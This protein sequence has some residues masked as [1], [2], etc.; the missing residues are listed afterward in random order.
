[1]YLKANRRIKDGKQHIYYTLNESL[2]VN[3][4]RVIQRCVLHLG[5]LNTTQVERWQRT[6][7]T[8]QEDGQRHQLRLFTD[9]EGQAPEAE[10][11]A[12]VILSSLVLRRPRQFGAAWIGCKLWED[13][14]LRSFWNQALGED[15]GQVPWSNV[16]ELLAVNRLCAPGSELS[17]HEKWYPQTA[18]DMLLG[19]GDEV[20]ERNRLYR[21]LDRLLP[22]KE[23]LEKHLAQRWK[24]L[25]GAKFDILLYDLTSTYFEGEVAEVTKAERGYSRDSRPDCKQLVIALVVTLEGFPLSYEVFDGSRSDVTTLD[26]IVEAVER[27]H[28]QAQ[29]V[30]VFDRG[31]VSEDNL[32]KLRKRKALYLVGTRKS[33][34]K[35]HEQRLLQ[36]DWQK[37]SETVGVQIIPDGE[38]TYVLARSLTRAEKERAMR[39]RGIYG[40]MRELIR[41][42]RSIRVGKIIDSQK[43]THRLGRLHE[44]YAST[45]RYVKVE[46]LGERLCWEWDR[47]ALGKAALRDGAYLLRTNISGMDA[48]QL[49][50][51]YIQLTEVESAFR[52]LKGQLAVR[53]IWHWISSR[54]EAHVMVAF[55]GY[56]LWVT[57][58]QKLCA[59]AQSLTPWQLLDQFGRIQLIEVWFK[60]RD[61]RAICLPRITQPEPAQ[62]LLLHQLGWQLPAQPPPRVYQHQLLN[63]WET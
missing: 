35:K 57:L 59:I 40:L 58:K 30:W 37:V 17:I 52:A 44:R 29:R 43:I 24:D 13:L 55:L 36:G 53:P 18:M 39:E 1:M 21:C 49:W 20:A 25:F 46:Y 62:A 45:W 8:I 14:G 38:D 51:N 19:C 34:L 3:R 61:G 42:R 28:G 27:K 41:L 23:A 22:H 50:R 15:A 33:W 6:I 11:V 32:L 48:G 2:R 31:I 12:E 10:D 60:T 4:K 54:V 63:V 47:D 16:V 7:E 56:A 9:R 5:E 26:E